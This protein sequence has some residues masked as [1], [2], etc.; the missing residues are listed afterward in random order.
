MPPVVSQVELLFSVPKV[1]LNISSSSVVEAFEVQY[2]AYKYEVPVTAAFTVRAPPPAYV[3]FPV[4]DCKIVGLNLTY[5]GVLAS[6][7]LV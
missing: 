4:Y 6:D 5:T 3:I 7:A 2:P 1:T